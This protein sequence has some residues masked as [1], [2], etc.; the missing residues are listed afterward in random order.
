M[1]ETVYILGAGASA[2]A[3]AP[4][5]K[6][7]IDAA[8]QTEKDR[9]LKSPE[10]V[11]DF[12]LV[13]D[14]RAALRA[15]HQ[16]SKIDLDDL[17]DLLGA[18]EMSTLFEK[19]ADWPAD[20]IRE[21]PKAVRTV[22]ARTLWH[23]IKFPVEKENGRSSRILPPVPYGD[24]AEL[25]ARNGGG[26]GKIA[27]LTF[28]YDIALD[29]ALHSE[30]VPFSY[31]LDAGDKTVGVE[32]LKLHGS[33]NWGRC[34]ECG[35]IKPLMFNEFFSK[36]QFNLYGVEFVK[37]DLAK[38][39]SQLL[40][41]HPTGVAPEP[42]IVPPTWNKG[43]HHKQI[44]AVWRRAA[45]HL[46][47]AENIFVIGYSYP[48]SDQFF[49]YLFALGTLGDGWLRDIEIINPDGGVYDRMRKL[50]GPLSADKLHSSKSLFHAWVAGEKSR[51]G[52]ISIGGRA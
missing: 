29:Y 32:Y 19:L 41:C 25:L 42:V 12:R 9:V 44:A 33:L 27:I 35:K 36:R 24:F 14:A 48:E 30:G 45:N 11:S 28:N 21:L 23:G 4:V 46:A 5:L 40:G 8:I 15:V 34:R 52:V 2:S 22:I 43:D 20:R 16:K 31:M 37:V 39:L 49:K 3:G 18:F 1:A 7:F 50:M 6:G 47:E 10:D 38:E 13:L 51:L 26:D 17:E